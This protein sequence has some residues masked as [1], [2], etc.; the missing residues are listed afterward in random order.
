VVW[1][2]QGIRRLQLAQRVGVS[3]A[4]L[5]TVTVELPESHISR[6]IG[7]GGSNLRSIEEVRDNA[8]DHRAPNT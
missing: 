5:V 3:A 7:K 2:V 8:R 1:C 4:D 6:V